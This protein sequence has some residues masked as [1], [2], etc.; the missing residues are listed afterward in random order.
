MH[1]SAKLPHR[2]KVIIAGNHDLPFDPF[3]MKPE[4]A[5]NLKRF[6]VTQ[7]DVNE[8]LA[9]RGFTQIKE[10]L[11]C[12]N[13]IYLEDSLAEICGVTFYGSPWYEPVKLNRPD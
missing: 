11:N 8:D 10:I 7:E 6:G 9:K 2:R 4:N 1:F 5:Q 12:K 13:L 3:F